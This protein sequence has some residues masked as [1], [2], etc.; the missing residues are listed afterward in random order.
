M[1]IKELIKSATLKDLRCRL[2]N[3][4]ISSLELTTA[5]LEWAEEINPC[6]NAFITIEGELALDTAKKADEI[7]AKEAKKRRR[8]H[9][10]YI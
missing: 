9:A 3:R 2:D 1:D 6:L 7:I 5:Y 10:K 8:E 4:D